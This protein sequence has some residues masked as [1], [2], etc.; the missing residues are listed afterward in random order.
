MRAARL[1]VC[2]SVCATDIQTDRQSSFTRPVNN[3]DVTQQHNYRVC[4]INIVSISTNK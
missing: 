2:M 4:T 3:I 1:Y